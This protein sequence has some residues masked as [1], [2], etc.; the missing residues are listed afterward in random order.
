MNRQETAIVVLL[1]A[2]MLAWMFFFRPTPPRDA[3]AKDLPTDMHAVQPVVDA[4]SPFP[5]VDQ[6]EVVSVTDALGESVTRTEAVLP[7]GPA[8][9]EVRYRLQNEALELEVSSRGAAVISALLREYRA[10]N[11]GD[12]EPVMLDYATS[13]ALAYEGLAGLSA[14]ADFEVAVSDD[15]REAVLECTNPDGL[16]MRR[17]VRLNDGH[18]AVITDKIANTG[19]ETVLVPEHTIA[20]GPMEMIRNASSMR[21]LSYLGVDIAPEAAGQGIQHWG[22]KKL[23]GLFGGKTGTFSCSR[24]PVQSMPPKAVANFGQPVL[25]VATKNKFFAQILSPE[26][27]AADCEIL[28]GRDTTAQSL[29]VEVVNARLLFNSVEL[30]PGQTIKKHYR[31][32]IGPKKYDELRKLGLHWDEVMEFGFFKP[33]C[34]LLLPVLNAIYK[35]LPN[36]GVAIILLTVLVRLVFWPITHKSTESMKKMQAIQPKVTALREKYKK[37]PQRMNRE[38]MALYKENKVNPMAGCLPMLVQIPVF[39]GLFTVLRSAVEL[40]FA[41]FLWISDLSEPEGLLRGVLPF[42]E[43]GLNVLP[44]YMTVTMV[45]QQQLTPTAGDPQQK[46]MMMFMPVIMLLLFYGM[47]SA[48]VLYWSTSQTLAIVQL[49]L[50]RRQSAAKA[51]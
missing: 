16:H 4:D 33:I 9:P 35:V 48:L 26:G 10:E 50:Q 14:D 44:V 25:W 43:S 6:A 34:K 21:G 40:R 13:P 28:A 27:S 30:V 47:P 42:P 49:L 31:Y 11:T 32:Y 12:S 1:F 17:V 20:V 3:D 5:E 7:A 37:D 8:R 19:D 51:A 22:G 45:L 39:I 23:P 41:N 46:K 29:D 15:G 38:V 36:Y 24:M 2:A 18:V